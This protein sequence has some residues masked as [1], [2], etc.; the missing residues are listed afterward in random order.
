MGLEIGSHL[1]IPVD[2]KDR[3]VYLSVNLIWDNHFP[4]WDNQTFGDVCPRDN[5]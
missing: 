5:H 3:T 2:M 1:V 4:I